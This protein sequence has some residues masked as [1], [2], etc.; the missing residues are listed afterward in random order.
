MRGKKRRNKPLDRRR[1]SNTGSTIISSNT[2]LEGGAPLEFMGYPQD[3]IGLV[4]PNSAIS[5]HFVG[6]AKN[7]REST[8][9][10]AP[11][12]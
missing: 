4:L 11:S 1:P 2:W 10:S 6:R 9:G 5:S 3:L 12:K 8:L 7:L